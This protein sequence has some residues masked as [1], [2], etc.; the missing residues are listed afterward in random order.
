[1]GDPSTR[2]TCRDLFCI[3][4]GGGDRKPYEKVTC[5]FFRPQA[6]EALKEG[7]P[8]MTAETATHPRMLKQDK[9]H[10]KV[11]LNHVLATMQ[12]SRAHTW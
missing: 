6:L 1:M 11:L 8:T 2:C 7:A 4:A 10:L 9:E 3:L 12:L 5:A